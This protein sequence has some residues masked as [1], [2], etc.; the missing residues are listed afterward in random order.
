VKL[1]SLHSSKGLE[2][3][4]VFISGVN[5]GLIPMTDDDWG[6]FPEEEERLFYVGITRAKD[7][8]ELS[9]YESPCRSGYYVD[10]KPSRFLEGFM[11]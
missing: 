4:H 8:L 3:K 10:D 5:E 11:D 7:T 6:Y 2:F 9:W 1:M